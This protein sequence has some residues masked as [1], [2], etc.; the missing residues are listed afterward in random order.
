MKTLIDCPDCG[1]VKG[2]LITDV[3]QIVL[4]GYKCLSC[5]TIYRPNKILKIVVKPKRKVGRPKKRGEE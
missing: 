2:E 5:D 1:V 4:A 3:F